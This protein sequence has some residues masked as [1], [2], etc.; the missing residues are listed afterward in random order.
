MY[1]LIDGNSFYASCERV[2]RPDLKNRPVVVLSNND[3]CIVT[4]TKEAKTLGLK[5]GVPLFQVQDIIKRNQVAV[6]SS[7]YELYGDMSARMMKTI[8]SLTPAIEV[9]SIDECF[10]D[11]SGLSDLTA[12]GFKIRK[13]IWRWIGIPACVGIA[14]TKTLAKYCNHLAKK[15]PALNGVLNWNDLTPERQRKALACLSVEEVWGVGGRLS[16][17]MLRLGIQTPL[18]LSE[19][20]EALLKQCF[21]SNVVDTAKELRGIKA[22]DF[23]PTAPIRQRLVRSRSFADDVYDKNDLLSAIT[24]HA[25]EAARVLREERLV[26]A[27]VGV[28]IFSNRFKSDVPAYAAIDVIELG[29]HVNDTPTILSSAEKL[30]HRLFRKGVAYKKAGVVLSDIQPVY[31]TNGDLLAFETEKAD[32]LSEVIDRINSKYGRDTVSFSAVK[33]NSSHWKMRRDM[34][35]PSYTTR[36]S[37]VLV[38]KT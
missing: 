2:F 6:F 28:F 23:E 9:Y 1:A 25:Q 24:M 11:L 36:F 22:I 38:I 33:R 18:D 13:R 27:K 31:E 20:S 30:L 12:L 19:V 34:K 10:A 32:K 4:L 3:G 37:D 5:R 7:N 16:S 26:A 8:A 21:P 29:H 17:R 35:S 15:I 14:P